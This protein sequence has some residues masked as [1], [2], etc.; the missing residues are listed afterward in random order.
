M[1]Q[2]MG[3]PPIIVSDRLR[4]FCEMGLLRTV[5]ASSGSGRTEYRL[6]D[7]GRAFFPHIVVMLAWGVAALAFALSRFRW[8]PRHR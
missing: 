8:E 2:M 6:T 5:V 7:K 1:L 4:A 3:A